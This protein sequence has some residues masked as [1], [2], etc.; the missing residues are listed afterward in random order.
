MLTVVNIFT[1]AFTLSDKHFSDIEMF[2]CVPSIAPTQTYL[3]K[4]V[5]LYILLPLKHRFS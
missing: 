5:I 3:C 4:L 2:L 1:S